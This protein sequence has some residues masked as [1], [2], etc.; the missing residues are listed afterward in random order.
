MALAGA[1]FAMLGGVF[2]MVS[3]PHLFSELAAFFSRISSADIPFTFSQGFAGWGGIAAF[4]TGMVGVAVGILGLIGA[5]SVTKNSQK[6]GVLMIVAAGLRMLTGGGI[7]FV[8]LLLGGI[9][10]LIKEKP[11]AAEPPNQEV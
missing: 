5:T 7:V 3:G 8:L 1:F 9:F 10:A 11:Q 2:M 6:A 4:F